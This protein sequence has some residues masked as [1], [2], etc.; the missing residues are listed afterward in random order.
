M[1][2]TY[3]ALGT[4]ISLSLL[5]EDTKDT[6][7]KIVSYVS[8]FEQR[9]S[10]FIDTSEIST[11]NQQA[12]ISFVKV[13]DDTFTIIKKALEMY[14][15]TNHA[16]DITIGSSYDL[17]FSNSY[18]PSLIK[19]YQQKYITGS[20]YICINELTKEVKL[21]K[22]NQKINL[23]G[24]AKGYCA[25]QIKNIIAR[26]SCQKAIINLG[27]DISIYNPTFDII[28]VGIQDPF[29]KENIFGTITITNEAIVTSGTYE[30]Y[31][32]QIGNKAHHI[33]DPKTIKPVDTPIM[34]VTVLYQNAMIADT[35]ATSFLLLGLKASISLLNKYKDVSV[36]FI[37]KDKHIYIS[38]SLKNRFIS[39]AYIHYI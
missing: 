19:R 33:I 36:I 23:G 34:S 32:E 14:Q 15:E 38:S 11:I 6:I 35:L 16:F 21:E 37:L 22:R 29:I 5:G 28:T 2:Y 9:L 27:G 13:S 39:D 18:K 12:G 10:Y 31:N 17:W 3:N 1:I 30:R 4:T 8:D 26:S 7:S 25:D 24:I 20:H